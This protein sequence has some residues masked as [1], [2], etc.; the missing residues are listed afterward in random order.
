MARRSSGSGAKA[1]EPI[2]SDLPPELVAD[3]KRLGEM[4]AEGDVE[5][6]RAWVSE[7]QTR[8]PESERVRHYARVLAPPTVRVV[9]GGGRS[10]D[11]ERA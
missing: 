9:P 10:F 1:A 3:L 8:W 5:G 6:A 4:L 11:Q 2:I 7:L